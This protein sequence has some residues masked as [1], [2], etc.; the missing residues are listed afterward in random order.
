MPIEFYEREISDKSNAGIAGA[1]NIHADTSLQFQSIQKCVTLIDSIQLCLD[2]DP[3]H[4]IVKVCVNSPL[5]QIGCW[6]LDKDHT[7]AHIG[8]DIGLASISVDICA[9]W[10]AK[11]VTLKGTACYLRKCTKWDVVII[12]W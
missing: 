8:V 9:N 6:V 1:I 11:Q 4:L 3:A 12:Q 7:C 2:A 5:G 10:N